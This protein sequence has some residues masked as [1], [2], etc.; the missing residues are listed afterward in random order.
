MSHEQRTQKS[1]ASMFA[2]PAFSYLLIWKSVCC[3]D[4]IKEGVKHFFAFFAKRF[5]NE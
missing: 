1:R 5:D 3:F 2:G 4:G